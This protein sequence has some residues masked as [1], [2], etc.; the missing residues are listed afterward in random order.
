MPLYEF[1]CE[2]CGT[3]VE[4]FFPV[5][6]K[7]I[8]ERIVKPCGNCEMD[9]NFKKVLSLS[10][11]KL[12]GTCWARDGYIMQEFDGSRVVDVQDGRDPENP[13]NRR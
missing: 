4:E 1:E 8:P 5:I 12:K 11:F 10:T 3:L 2:N 7:I 9:T 13:I 6:P